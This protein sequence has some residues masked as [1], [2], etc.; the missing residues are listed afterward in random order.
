MTFIKTKTNRVKLK[1]SKE[2]RNFSFLTFVKVNKK[3]FKNETTFSYSTLTNYS[4]S[5]QTWKWKGRYKLPP[6]GGRGVWEPLSHLL[7]INFLQCFLMLFA[8]SE[9]TRWEREREKREMFLSFCFVLASW[10]AF[11]LWAFLD[12]PKSKSFKHC[13]VIC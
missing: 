12:F 1:L 4:T 13:N 10:L 5:M 7:F 11:N 6:N 2:T 8:S 9:R 3:I